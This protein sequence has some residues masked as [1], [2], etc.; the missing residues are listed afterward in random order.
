[1]FRKW[2]GCS[3]RWKGEIDVNRIDEVLSLVDDA[4]VNKRRRHLVGGILVSVSLLFCG[5]AYTV[6]TLRIEDDDDDNG[7]F[8]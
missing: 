5:L 8:Y 6:I 2:Y 7:R 1:M 4:L 3:I